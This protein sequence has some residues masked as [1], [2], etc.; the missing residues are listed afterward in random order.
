MDS[1]R[2]VEM[3]ILY[4]I[5]ATGNGHI[6]RAQEII[7]LLK[8]YGEVDILLSGTNSELTLPFEIKYRFEG[9]SLFYKKSG[10]LDELRILKQIHP[11][12]LAKDAKSIPVESYDLVLIDYEFISQLACKIKKIPFVHFGHQASFHSNETTKPPKKS[13]WKQWILKNYCT[14]KQNIGFHFEQPED[15]IFPPV[16]KDVMWQANP[17]D[18]G[19]ISV[20]LPHYALIQFKKYFYGLNKTQFH[21]FSKEI[22]TPYSD[23]N[24][25]FFPISHVEF[26]HS[27]IHCHG[28]ICSAGFETPSEALFLNKKL[29]VVPIRGQ[30][31]QQYNAVALEKMGVLVVPRIDI[32]FSL[33]VSNWLKSEQPI[34]PKPQFIKTPLL[35]ETIFH[36]IQNDWVNLKVN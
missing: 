24:L 23:L 20:Y 31:E 32:H 1:K 19:H 27:L 25:H 36:K 26:N 21:I 14:S 2:V 28:V 16:I 13:K 5:Q 4:S 17:S 33:I 3:K 35:I 18:R 8:Q 22:D 9:L 7:P 10:K 29:L 15:W 6:S 34:H 30:Y 12:K 11:K